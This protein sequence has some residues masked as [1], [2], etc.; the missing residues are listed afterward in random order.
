M[1]FWLALHCMELGAVW[2][3]TLRNINELLEFVNAPQNYVPVALFAIGWPA[4][5]PE[6]KGRKQLKEITY[7]EKYGESIEAPQ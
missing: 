2:I 7:L 1:Y 4:E 6:P 3:Q 5:Q